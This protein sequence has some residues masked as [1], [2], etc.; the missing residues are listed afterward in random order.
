MN[1]YENKYKL[2][3]MADCER[4]SEKPVSFSGFR[5]LLRVKFNTNN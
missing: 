2:Q 5:A 3:Y 4:K 1:V